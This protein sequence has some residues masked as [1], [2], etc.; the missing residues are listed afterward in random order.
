[1]N[2]N[3]NKKIF[4]RKKIIII[5]FLVLTLSFSPVAA[6]KT[7]AWDAVLGETFGNLM[8]KTMDQIDAVIRGMQ[9]QL[10][11]MSINQMTIKLVANGNNGPMFIVNWQDYLIGQ[12]QLRTQ[13]YMN[14]YLTQVTRGRGS[15]S[16]YRPAPGFEGT[17]PNA[18]RMGLGQYGNYSSR[19]LEQ[20][21]VAI[22]SPGVA[23]TYQGNPSQ[24]FAKGNFKDMSTFLSGINNPWAFQTNAQAKKQEILNQQQ[25]IAS[26]EAVAGGGFTGVKKN[27]QTLTP[28]SV[29]KENLVNA[30]DLGNKIIASATSLPE[31]ITGVVSKMSTQL[32]TQGIGNIQAQ[33]QKNISIG[34]RAKLQLNAQVNSRGPGALY[35]R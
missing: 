35:G 5:L 20:T 31:I 2:L 1:M 21:K 29:V 12:P 9:K 16:G 14:D 13:A 33:V 32:M 15:S 28:G 7:Y 19:L 30:Q 27:G 8:R 6:K 26:N 4:F 22:S 25:L 10:S 11:A 3:Q 17:G 24:M 34:N 23:M 18:F